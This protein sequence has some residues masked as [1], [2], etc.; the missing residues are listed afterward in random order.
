MNEHPSKSNGEKD[1]GVVDKEVEI[2]KSPPTPK[3]EEK[4]QLHD[5]A[6]NYIYETLDPKVLKSIKDMGMAHKV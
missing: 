2:W 3:E 1:L 6:H 4:L 5:Q